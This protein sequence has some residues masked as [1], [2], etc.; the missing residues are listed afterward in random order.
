[1]QP[2]L[3]LVVAD[4]LTELESRLPA[5]VGALPLP[6]VTVTE[7]AERPVGLGNRSGF[8]DRGLLGLVPLKA[9][10]LETEVRFQLWA[11]DPVAVDAAVLDLQKELL[12]DKDELW[13]AGFL[14]LAASGTTLA[15]R[16]DD[17]AAWRKTATYTLLY[18]YSYEETDSTE[19]LIAR[20]PINSDLEERNST[21]Q[22]TSVVTDEMVRWDEEGS[23]DLRVGGPGRLSR[24]SAL[25]FLP[26]GPAP[27]GNVTLLRTFIGAI[28]A[29]TP[30]AIPAAFFDAVG[31]PDPAER[32]A[33]LVFPSIASFLAALAVDGDPIEMGDWDLDTTLDA[34]QP[35]SLPLDPAVELPTTDDRFELIHQNNSLDQVA[36]IYLRLSRV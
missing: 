7:L 35:R 17:L 23:P 1:M 33:E 10:R 2:S 25:S 22:E 12:E 20:I 34:Y 27:T 13:N 19:S 32:H 31:G 28:G 15:E 9:G 14:R 29:P 4:L 24:L 18:E 3:D 16:V 6:N 26:A 8:E 11:A 21:V 5:P 30:H 36:V